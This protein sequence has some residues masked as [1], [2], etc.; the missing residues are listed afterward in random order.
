VWWS[1]LK[2]PF[3]ELFPTLESVIFFCI[4]VSY[5]LTCSCEPNSLK[6]EFWFAFL[7]VLT[8]Y[9]GLLLLWKSSLA[10]ML[11]LFVW[12]PPP[13]VLLVI[14]LSPRSVS[15]LVSWVAAV[16]PARRFPWPDPM[17]SLTLFRAWKVLSPR[18]RVLFSRIESYWRSTIWT[19]SWLIGDASRPSFCPI[20]TSVSGREAFYWYLLVYSALRPAALFL[21]RSPLLIPLPSLFVCCMMFPELSTPSFCPRDERPPFQ[22]AG[23]RDR[24]V[25]VSVSAAATYRSASPAFFSGSCF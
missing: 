23:S 12:R 7:R 4:K 9:S 10:T 3:L 18:L 11:W 16:T 22:A 13:R 24:S 6:M 19:L 5:V 17:L 20:V 8:F 15:W 14:R 2:A 21:E 1:N 25:P